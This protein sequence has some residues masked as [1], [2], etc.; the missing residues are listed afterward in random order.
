MKGT[1]ASS[2]QPQD[3]KENKKAEKARTE[4]AELDLDE[5]MIASLT[6]DARKNHGASALLWDDNLRAIARAHSK[7]MHENDYYSHDNQD[8]D[9][10]TERGLKAG[11]RCKN[12]VYNGLS[13]NLYQALGQYMTPQ[14]AVTGW[15]NSPGH[16]RNMLDPFFIR[17][18]IGI[19]GDPLSS[20]G[21]W[22]YTMLLC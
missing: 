20:Y 15:M 18:G 5:R 13:E 16:R 14:E 4:A 3:A 10:P 1:K 22:Y 8:G 12:I 17:I 6:N 7:D 2:Q 11:Y 19:H 21:V 9:G